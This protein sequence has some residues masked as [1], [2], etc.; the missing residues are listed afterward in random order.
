M[1]P[2]SDRLIILKL[3]ITLQKSK[4]GL[5]LA[6][7]SEKDANRDAA[8]G[9]VIFV[10]EGRYLEDGTLRPCKCKPDDIIIFNERAPLQCPH[11]EMA[12]KTLRESDVIAILTPDEMEGIEYIV[13]E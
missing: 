4:G 2:I 6:G 9:K 1:I 10:G 5:F 7:H 3:D 8:Y 12:Y 11:K 13:Q